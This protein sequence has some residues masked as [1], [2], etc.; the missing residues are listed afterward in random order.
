MFV[1]K[2]FNYSF[3]KLQYKVNLSI[4][5]MVSTVI[6]ISKNLKKPIE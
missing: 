3:L 4:F 6:V 1:F 2:N 5:I